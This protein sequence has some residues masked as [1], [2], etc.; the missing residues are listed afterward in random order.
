MPL[1]HRRHLRT[2]REQMG[3]PTRKRL[4]LYR[5]GVAIRVSL[6]LVLSVFPILDQSVMLIYLTGGPCAWIVVA[7]VWPLSARP[8]GIALGASSNW[9][10][11][12]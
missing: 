6:R 1:H 2:K 3:K 4:G 8:Y 10:N 7:E 9:M 5:H 12:L 11:N